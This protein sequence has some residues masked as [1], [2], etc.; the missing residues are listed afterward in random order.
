MT[1]LSF[2]CMIL[3]HLELVVTLP[4]F[5]TLGLKLIKNPLR[6]H[7]LSHDKWK[8]EH[9]R[10]TPW[11]KVFAQVAHVTFTHISLA[12]AICMVKHFINESQRS[13]K[14][15]YNNTIY[16]ILFCEVSAQSIHPFFSLII[17]LPPTTNFL[18][19]L[20]WFC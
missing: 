15:L 6:G 19:L 1:K 3:G 4:R 9:G 14:I 10:Y 17:S 11:I 5:Y 7:C 16:Q 13:V 18:V 2:S 8:G 20:L 12:K